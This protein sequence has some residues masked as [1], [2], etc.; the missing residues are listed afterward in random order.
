[1]S[2]VLAGVDSTAVAVPELACFAQLAAGGAFR[3]R[4]RLSGGARLYAFW[5]SDASGR[6]WGPALGEEFVLGQP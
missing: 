6:S 5:I 4:F 2:G 1:V 3:L